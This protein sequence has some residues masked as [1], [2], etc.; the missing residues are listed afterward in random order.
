MTSH[1][2]RFTHNTNT[3]GKLEWEGK[4]QVICPLPLELA[5]LR[6]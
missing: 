2:I 4:M 5:M 6:G 3:I 1:L